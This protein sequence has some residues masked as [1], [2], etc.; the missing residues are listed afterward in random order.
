MARRP[1][2]GASEHRYVHT[3]VRLYDELTALKDEADAA[4]TSVPAEFTA[5]LRR[6]T[7][8]AQYYM[9]WLM[10]L[11]GLG[12]EVWEPEA[13]AARQ[14]Y[15]LLAEDADRAPRDRTVASGVRRRLRGR[16]E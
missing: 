15:R 7:A 4:G 13:E 8:H 10:R 6:T 2:R 16:G 1:H 11:E 5:D 3:E 9:T 14:T 12:A